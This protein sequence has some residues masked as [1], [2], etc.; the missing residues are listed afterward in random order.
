MEELILIHILRIKFFGLSISVHICYSSTTTY[1][2]SARFVGE[3]SLT[4]TRFFVSLSCPT[5]V[6][7]CV[8]FKHE[9][10]ANHST[11]VIKTS[12]WKYM[13]TA[14]LC[15]WT[16]FFIVYKHNIWWNKEWQT[17]RHSLVR[18][19]HV[20]LRVQSWR[21]YDR[22]TNKLR[23]SFETYTFHRTAENHLQKVSLDCAYTTQQEHRNSA[24]FG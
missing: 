23:S 10:F 2:S 19:M 1:Y 9:P 12:L 20:H 22:Q 3:V 5:S 8:G 6:H 21:K 24:K 17:E 7:K 15:D 14:S 16:L 11:V 13:T 4:R 18:Y